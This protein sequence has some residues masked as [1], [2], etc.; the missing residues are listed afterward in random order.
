MPLLISSQSRRSLPKTALFLTSLICYG[1]CGPST[2]FTSLEKILSKVNCDKRYHS[3]SF[4][5]TEV[6][7]SSWRSSTV[8]MTTSL[9]SIC[10]TQTQATSFRS[11]KASFTV[12]LI[13]MKTRRLIQTRSLSIWHSPPRAWMTLISQIQ[14]LWW[15]G[16]GRFSRGYRSIKPRLTLILCAYF[17]ARSSPGWSY[18]VTE[19]SLSFRSTKM[20]IWSSTKQNPSTCA[21]G[22]REEGNL[23]PT[24][25]RKYRPWAQ[26]WGGKM[27]SCFNCTSSVI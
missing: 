12:S 1:V 3:R 7:L 26:I 5:R 13:R 27:K 17:G 24:G 22:S 9:M 23:M 15:G 2:T 8:W 16:R 6:T 20:T 4:Q 25:T 19:A 21:E 14:L 11:I 18:F 10:K